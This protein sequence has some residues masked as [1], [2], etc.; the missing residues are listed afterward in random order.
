MASVCGSTLSLMDAG[1]KI[2]RPISG[3][4]M[5]LLM[6]SADDYHILTDIQAAEDFGG[7]M[8]FKVTGDDKGITALQL[9]I[10]IKGLKIELLAEALQ[11]AQEGRTFIL[12]EML[13]VIDQPREEMNNFAPRVDAFKINPD[14]IRVVIGK[15]GE[16][17]QGLT[18]KY[19]VEISIEDDGLVMITA[20]DQAAGK[21][22][23]ADIEAMTYEP[24][25]GDE[26]EGTVKKI[27]EFGAFVE[28][29]PSKEALVH[30][31]EIADERVEQV[32]D[33]LSEGQKV[34]VKYLGADKMGRVKLTMK[35][36]DQG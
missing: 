12:N 18:A 30:I 14:Y 26:F 10:K 17:I 6:N 24:S 32:T 3:I 4:A 27:M 8:D 5:G 13:E 33:Y 19:G 21:A 25:L 22:A 1:I 16:T 20:V 2:K 9:D 34:K 15:G 29:L 31:S 23:R 35:G 36:L 7:D 28:Y 11:K